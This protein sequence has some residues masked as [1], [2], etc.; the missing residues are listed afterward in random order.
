VVTNFCYYSRLTVSLAT[1]YI[2]FIISSL[3]LRWSILNHIHIEIEGVAKAFRNPSTGELLLISK[4]SHQVNEAYRFI[5]E[6]H[7]SDTDPCD[8]E[9]AFWLG[10]T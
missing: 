2:L 6:H 1:I 3:E 7:Q 4:L 10:K 9:H 5:R 8:Q